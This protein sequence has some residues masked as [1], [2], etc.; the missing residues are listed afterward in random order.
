MSNLS[1]NTITD[2]SGGSTASINGLTP[3]AS[4]MQPFNRIINGAM[5]VDQ[6]NAGASQA[7]SADFGAYTTDRFYARHVTDGALTF[8]QVTDAPTGFIN[9][10]KITVTTADSSIASTQRAWVAQYI[11][12][13][14]VSDLAWGTASAINVTLSFW[15]K[16]SVTGIYCC[17]IINSANNRGHPVNYTINSVNTWEQKTVTISGD[18]SGTWLTTNGIG[19]RVYFPVTAGTYYQ[20]TNSAWNASE[21]M[22]TS[23]QTN[24]MAT[25]GATFYITGV[26]LEAGSSASSFAHE[27]YSDTLRKC[28]R[29]FV[30]TTEIAV[31]SNIATQYLSTTTR[32]N[33]VPM[34]ATPSLS[35]S[36]TW[37]FNPFFGSPSTSG[38]TPTLQRNL[39]DNF[40]INWD[41]G[42][43]TGTMAFGEVYNATLS[44][45]AEL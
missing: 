29:Y 4:N 13:L 36:G 25:S 26:Q 18:T 24:L 27:N 21:A 22:C 1:V 12:G 39:N 9:S 41:A 8:Q 2:A 32:L 7:T 19:L 38:N 28:Q 30:N 23:S 40:I 6:R 42:A 16:S 31:M 14:N 20:G 11:E 34:R 15:V 5:T 35:I 10:L 37:T 45:I 44:I 17:S 33:P 3:Q 43:S